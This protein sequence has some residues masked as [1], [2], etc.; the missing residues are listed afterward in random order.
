MGSNW[1]AVYLV[2]ADN[3][4][5]VDEFCFVETVITSD[6]DISSEIWRRIVQG[7]HAY[8]GLHLLLG[9]RRLR[10]RTKCEIYRTLICPVVLYGVMEHSSGG[11]KRSGHGVWRRMNHE[12]AELYGDP[13]ILTVVKAGRIRLLGHVMRMPD[14]FPTKKVF[15]SDP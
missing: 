3:L 2:D 10:A 7:N 11:C 1:E 12:F 5:V 4:E 15:D 9:S 13:S 6:N 14:S 8:H